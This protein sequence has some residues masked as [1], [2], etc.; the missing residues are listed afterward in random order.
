M[1]QMQIHD[2]QMQIHD[3]QIQETETK[4]TQNWRTII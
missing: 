1:R 4:F 2:L 3:L